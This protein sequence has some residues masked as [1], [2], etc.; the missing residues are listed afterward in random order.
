MIVT[1]INESCIC[2]LQPFLKQVPSHV[3]RHAIR[4]VCSA[5]LEQDKTLAADVEM[6]TEFAEPPIASR[7]VIHMKCVVYK[8]LILM[9]KM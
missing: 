8:K 1:M 7:I 4:L 5:W 2:V 3:V 6:R 9:I